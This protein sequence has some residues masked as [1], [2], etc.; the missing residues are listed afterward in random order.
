MSYRRGFLGIE[1]AQNS[2]AIPTFD[3]F[4]ARIGVP[5]RVI[6]IGTAKGGLSMFL[7][8]YCLG[9]GAKFTSIDTEVVPKYVRTLRKIGCKRVI[10]D[11]FTVRHA[12]N[13]RQDMMRE[14]VTVL[15]CDGGNKV[16]EF[17]EFA[18]SLKPGDFIL[19]HDFADSRKTWV[20]DEHW[21]CCEIELSDIAWTVEAFGLERYMKDEFTK[22]A[23]C[24]FKKVAK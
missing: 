16:R 4:F 23:W 19:A 20:K 6:E 10:G 17:N 21:K 12:F 18:Q 13:L 8:L 7:A 15:L 1:M 14:G 9:T 11:V 22:A 24:C 3:E 2:V 5:A